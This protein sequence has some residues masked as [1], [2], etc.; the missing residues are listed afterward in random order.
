M[1]VPVYFPGD[2]RSLCLNSGLDGGYHLGFKCGSRGMICSKGVL[3]IDF[4]RP[5]T[6]KFRKC[7]L[8]L[9]VGCFVRDRDGC[10]PCC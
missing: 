5:S 7:V 1:L 4:V 10:W 2:T 9:C 6:L 8:Q 3:L